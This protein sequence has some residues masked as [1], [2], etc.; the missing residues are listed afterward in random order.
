LRRLL[1]TSIPVLAAISVASSWAAPQVQLRAGDK[2][3]TF[4]ILALSRVTIPH[5][6][7]P[8]G[9]E[10]RGDWISYRSLLVTVGPLFGKKKK[11]TPVGFEAG[12][13]TWTSATAARITST[14]TFRGQGTIK[15]RGAITDHKD[16]TSTI[17]IVGG[18]GK[19]TGA[20]GVLVISPGTTLKAV[21][22]YRLRL[23]ETGVA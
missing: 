11:F 10:N 14:A 2:K 3:M 1:L 20:R 4:K 5:D 8:K 12:K 6:L 7:A 17:P 18:T 9:R 23:P 19:F 22:T 16:G 13:Y 21:N 15:I